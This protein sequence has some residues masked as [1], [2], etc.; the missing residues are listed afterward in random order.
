MGQMARVRDVRLDELQKQVED[1]KEKTKDNTGLQENRDNEII[2][3]ISLLV[4]KFTPAY[5]DNNV[6]QR[7]MISQLANLEAKVEQ[8]TFT[9]N[10]LC[11]VVKDGNGQPSLMHRL[12]T[13]ETIQRV[14][15]DDIKK[16]EEY[17]NIIMQA[18]YTT[19]KELVVGMFT[20]IAGIVT[21]FVSYLAI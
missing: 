18:K 3:I 11:K 4:N 20:A 17:N 6:E 5:V 7:R 12:T 14:Q 13:V 16:L 8:L 9:I 2:E 15:D 21:L 19:R 10:S 1:L